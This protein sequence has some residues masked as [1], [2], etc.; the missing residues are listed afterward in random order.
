MEDV[1]ASPVRYGDRLMGVAVSQ[2]RVPLERILKD[3][4]RRVKLLKRVASA[5]LRGLT[6]WEAK[7]D[8]A[9]NPKLRKKLG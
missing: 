9:L 7:K 2:D 8:G 1:E 3:F 5:G 4:R 6:W